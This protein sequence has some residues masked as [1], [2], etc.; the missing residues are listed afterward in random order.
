MDLPPASRPGRLQRPG[1]VTLPDGST[2][3]PAE[4]AALV[5]A[6]KRHDGNVDRQTQRHIDE[7]LAAAAHHDLDDHPKPEEPA[8]RF[9]IFGTVALVACLLLM[10]ALG[11]SKNGMHLMDPAPAAP[12]TRVE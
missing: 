11:F 9:A 8:S 5:A 10:A 7:I 1:K 12:L 3:G 2:L 6:A 4:F